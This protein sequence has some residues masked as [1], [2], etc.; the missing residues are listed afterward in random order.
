M[1]DE[2]LTARLRIRF[3]N[4]D[5]LEPLVAIF[6]KEEVWRFPF[7]RG[8]TREETA[9]YLTRRIDWQEAGRTG[10][11]AAEDR[12]S[13]RLLGYIAL[14]LPEWLPEVMPAVE[15]GWRLDPAVWGQGLA[16]EGARAVLDYGFSELALE[17]ILAIYEPAN[18]ASGRVIEK[19]EM[20]FQRDTVHPMFDR[21]LRIHGLSR[22]QWEGRR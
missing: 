9:G 13:G 22:A 20:P 16:A 11:S 10:P 3:W 19:L 1:G 17:E 4:I 21:A 15:I 5:D 7:G 18:L 2:L 6:A 14:S 12:D 8:F